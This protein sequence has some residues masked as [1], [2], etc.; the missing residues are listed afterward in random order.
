MQSLK[1]IHYNIKELNPS[2]QTHLS[3]LKELGVVDVKGLKILDLG[4]GSGYL[5]KSFIDQ[6]AALAVGMDVE[7]PEKNKDKADS[8][9]HFVLA[10]LNAEN[11]AD[12]LKDE[13]GPDAFDLVLG[14][15][16]IEHLKS[17][18]GFLENIKTLS[19][20]KT[21][22]IL[23]TPNTNSWERLLKPKT[24][25]GALDGDHLILFNAYSLTF[26]LERCGFSPLQVSAPIRK[27]GF[28]SK[29]F[30]SW[31]GQLLSKSTLS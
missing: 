25:S 19:H 1:K 30:F 31:G 14:F 16:I 5:C 2:D 28:F 24:W 18:V 21:K 12:Q 6:G 17:P 29:F 22:L 10:D 20:A 9:L 26:L 11:W 3:W 7:L 23:T 8:G 4:C 13:L 15:D 27:L